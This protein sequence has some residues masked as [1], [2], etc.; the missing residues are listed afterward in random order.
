MINTPSLLLIVWISSVFLNFKPPQGPRIDKAEQEKSLIEQIRVHKKGT[1]VWWAG[2]NSWIIKSGDMVV[3]TD[4]FLEDKD[5]IHPSPITAEELGPEL[6]ISFVTHDHGDHFN[7]ATSKILVETSQCIFVLPESCLAIAKTIGIPSDRIHIAR[8]REDYVIKGVEVKALRAIHG[9][10]DF[11][12]YYQANLQDCG[13]MINLNGTTFLQ[14][15]DS[16]L[17]EDHLFLEH[18]DVLFFSPT[19][20]NMYIDRSVILINRLQPNYIL[21]QHHSTIKYDETNRF[22]AN[23][24]PAEVKIRLA[25]DLKDRYYIMDPQG[26]RLDI[27]E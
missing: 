20:H 12:I 23:G 24:Y 21:P 22:W 1:T 9:N 14:P 11:A 15:G 2:H 7:Q 18:V 26:G 19:E 25:P 10:K 8:P 6:D 27:E 17:L 13:Y 3:A 5:R 16:Y 4:L